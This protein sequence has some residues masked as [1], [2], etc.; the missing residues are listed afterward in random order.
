MSRDCPDKRMALGGKPLFRPAGKRPADLVEDGE[1]VIHALLVTV[2]ADG[3]QEVRPRNSSPATL[4]HLGARKVG[5]P[6]ASA[7][8][9]RICRICYLCLAALHRS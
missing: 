5:H 6:S 1:E 4:S 3:Y 2:D 7:K 8:H 9:S